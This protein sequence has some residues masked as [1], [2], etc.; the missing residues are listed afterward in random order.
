[1]TQSSQP[2][3]RHPEWS[4]LKARLTNYKQGQEKRARS[5]GEEV[6]KRFMGAKTLTEARKIL[7]GES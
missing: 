5:K 3:G 2:Q 1:M 7:R 4:N 6:F